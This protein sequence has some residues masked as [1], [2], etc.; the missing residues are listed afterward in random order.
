MATTN[1]IELVEEVR[2]SVVIQLT[3]NVEHISVST[4]M[5][6]FGEGGPLEAVSNHVEGVITESFKDVAFLLTLKAESAHKIDQILHHFSNSQVKFTS[7]AGNEM[8]VTAHL[9]KP[10]LE[11]V[12]LHPVPCYIDARKITNLLEKYR[13]GKVN[14]MEFGYHRNF[15]HIKNGWLNIS[16][17][18]LNINN[19]PKIIKICGKWA[20]VTRPGESH[21][22]LCRFCKERGHVQT[23][24]PKKGYCNFCKA[25]GHIIKNCRSKPTTTNSTNTPW[26]TVPFTSK[27]NNPT[28]TTTQI[29]TSNKYA[30][31][32]TEDPRIDL[33]NMEIFPSLTESSS[34]QNKTP[35]PQRKKKQHTPKRKELESKQPVITKVPETK[36]PIKNPINENSKNQ[37]SPEFSDLSKNE[38]PERNIPNPQQA[39][40]TEENINIIE[41]YHSNLESNPTHYYSNISEMET[42]T[43]AHERYT[44][45]PTIRRS[46]G[47]LQLLFQ[48]TS[49][50][51]KKR[52]VNNHT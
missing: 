4:F 39:N 51:S 8:I 11:V 1:V 16:F 12:T 17:E 45:P 41:E 22:P 25:E 19:L 21:L 38:T 26:N 5:E 13:W 31:L 32:T 2:R 35:K 6:L 10:P 43:P 24:C 52:K 28:A 49:T 42:S 37:S 9:P 50:P 18:K 30:L 15:R 14:N 23:R 40:T 36:T 46:P 27:G 20:T 3:G 44:D 47:S 29:K 34:A 48:S 33:A 7:A